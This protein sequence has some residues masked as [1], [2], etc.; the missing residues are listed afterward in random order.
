VEKYTILEPISIR[1]ML[2]DLFRA[3]DT[4]TGRTVAFRVVRDEISGDPARRAALLADAAEAKA[5]S[6]PHIAALFDFGEQDGFLYLAH[7]Y[8]PGQPLSELLRG[9]PLELE[10]AV[11]LARQLADALAA[12]HGH[13]LFVRNLFPGSVIVNERDQAKLLD[14]GFARWTDAMSARL[15]QH[16]QPAEGQERQDDHFSGAANRPATYLAPE[17]VLGYDGDARADIFA[18]GI[19]LYQMLTGQ[20]PFSGASDSATGLKILHATPRAPATLNPA[21]PPHLDVLVSRMLLR[22]LDVRCSDAASVAAELRKVVRQTVNDPAPADPEPRRRP[23][24]VPA[25]VAGV[26]AAIG[27]VAWWLARS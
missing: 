19:I 11:H 15:G 27:L 17:Q 1:G 25:V 22:S 16:V 23:W 12:A 14:V 4:E 18:L 24:L 8:V 20:V 3:R 9:R 13:G 7:E 21:V 2:G 10:F 26:A 5:V 6:H